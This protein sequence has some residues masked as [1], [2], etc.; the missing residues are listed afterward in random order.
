MK[1]S[2]PPVTRRRFLKSTAQAAATF[3][4]LAAGSARTYAANERLN[5]AAIGIGGQGA[6]DIDQLKSQ[7]IVALCDVDWRHAAG[8][9]KKFPGAK[10]FKDYR[11]MFDQIPGE[12]DAVIVATPDHHH[13]P[14]TMAA[15]RLGKHVYCEKP[16]THSAWEARAIAQAARAAKVATQMG[17]Q[18]Q[19][20]EETRRLQEF[21]LD[22]AVGAIREVHIWTDRP[23][24][25]LFNEYWPQGVARPTDTPAVPDT[26]E[27]DLWLGPAPA[28][29]YHPAYL[30][31]K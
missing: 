14:A 29:P 30:P 2:L 26:L 7:N 3:T 10:P 25:G 5:I 19:A 4:I 1:S 9:F 23:S 12:F 17:N 27:W 31:A 18:A 11:R 28:R 21:V 13:A 6:G 24:Q 15:L 8:T 16:L 20:S 22:N